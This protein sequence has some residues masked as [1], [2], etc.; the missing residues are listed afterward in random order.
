MF[1]KLTMTNKDTVYRL[2]FPRSPSSVSFTFPRVFS[3]KE[4]AI[5]GNE[6]G[7]DKGSVGGEDYCFV[8]KK[9]LRLQSVWSETLILASLSAKK[10]PLIYF[11]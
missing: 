3:E 1:E 4:E 10:N 7:S 8:L 11:F 5:P 9:S 6:P 2:A